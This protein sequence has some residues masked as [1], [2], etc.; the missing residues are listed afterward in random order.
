M[1]KRS[2]C[3]SSWL[4]PSTAA[5]LLCLALL[6][7][8]PGVAHAGGS[9]KTV[10]EALQTL[11]ALYEDLDYEGALEQIRLAREGPRSK[12]EEM[13]LSLYEGILLCE[14]G[15]QAEGEKAFGTALLVRQ[16]LK[17]PVVVAPKIEQVFE[18]VRQ[19]VRTELAAHPASARSQGLAESAPTLSTALP[20]PVPVEPAQPVPSPPQGQPLH[21]E[22][23]AEENS[24]ASRRPRSFGVKS[25]EAADCQPAVGEECERLMKRLLHLQD[26][27]LR[28]NPPE[29]IPAIRELVTTG[30]QLRGA[31]TV[32][33]LQEARANLDYWQELYMRES[34]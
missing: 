22:K 25:W 8:A 27:Y 17:L 34:D 11:D 10:K 29:E 21:G 12:R 9:G 33:E 6:L 26:Q 5:G 1:A 15:K 31:R 13:L 30:Q 4:E 16:D 19:R 32:Q 2:L 14:T 24:L 20:R 18:S 3:A 7:G 23:T 28:T